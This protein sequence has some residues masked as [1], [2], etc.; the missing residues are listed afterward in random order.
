MELIEYG[1]LVGTVALIGRDIA[2][3]LYLVRAKVQK[4]LPG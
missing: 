1:R 3:A 4:D 2:E